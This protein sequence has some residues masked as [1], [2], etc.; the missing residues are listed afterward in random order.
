MQEDEEI[1]SSSIL[2]KGLI[3]FNN[4]ETEKAIELMKKI[5]VDYPKSSSFKVENAEHWV[6]SGCD[7]KNGDLFSYDGSGW[8]TDKIGVGSGDF[9]VLAIG[10]NIVGPAYMGMK[11]FKDG[12]W[13]FNASSMTFTQ[14]IIK[15][16]I[17]KKIMLNLINNSIAKIE[18]DPIH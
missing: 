8:E 5:I 2:N 11:E 1:L 17:V 7:L 14:S 9:S 3:Y 18:N 4:N 15:D 13:M 10:N 16:S 12:G 6:F